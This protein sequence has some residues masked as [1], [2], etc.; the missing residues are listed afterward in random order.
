MSPSSTAWRLPALSATSR[1][2]SRS[3][4][5]VVA[6]ADAPGFILMAACTYFDTAEPYIGL[7]S[8]PATRHATGCGAGGYQRRSQ[9][10]S[11]ELDM[12]P[13]VIGVFIPIVAI[14]MGIGIGM[15]AIWSE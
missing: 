6:G 11:G 15:L 5:A 12:D 8:I 2:L 13:A 1:S 7:Q 9:R 4:A 14:V 10:S 3:M